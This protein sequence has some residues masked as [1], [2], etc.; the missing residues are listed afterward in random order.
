[1]SK[2]ILIVDDEPDVR[3]FLSQLFEDA[4]YR[5]ETAQDGVEALEAVKR[6][7]PDMV[8]LDLQMPNDTGTAFYRKIHR[9]EPY[10]EIPIIVISGIAGRHLA[11]RKPFAVF[12]K[13][14]D[15]EELLA[16]TREA[17]GPT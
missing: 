11:I 15:P 1:M 5:T 14:I 3:V 9:L 10:N 12:D 16:K 13:P 4:G 6:V 2:T 7:K 17:L 8:T